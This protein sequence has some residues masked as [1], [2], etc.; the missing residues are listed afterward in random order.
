METPWSQSNSCLVQSLN[1]LKSENLMQYPSIHFITITSSVPG[2]DDACPFPGL[3]SSSGDKCAFFSFTLYLAKR[4]VLINP[5]V[6]KYVCMY[7]CVCV[8]IHMYESNT[9][10]NFF[11]LHCSFSYCSFE[12]LC[13]IS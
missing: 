4:D 11:L 2:S 1:T 3:W 13:P 12:F 9:D 5:Y 8:H 6:C 10:W 7:A